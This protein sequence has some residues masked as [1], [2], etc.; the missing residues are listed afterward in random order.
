V[1]ADNWAALSAAQHKPTD[2]NLLLNLSFSISQSLLFL[3]FFA[4]DLRTNELGETEKDE[5]RDLV[6][7]RC[8][9]RPAAAV[10][11]EAVLS[12]EDAASGPAHRL[13]WLPRRRLRC[14]RRHAPR[15]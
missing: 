7:G 9:Q 6:G 5:G 2:I 4:L 8:G 12:T 13:F 11:G 14:V 10:D 1:G 15:K 3:I